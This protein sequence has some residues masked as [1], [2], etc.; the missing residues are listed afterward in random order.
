MKRLDLRSEDQRLNDTMEDE[1]QSNA[2]NLL[3]KI[4][5][6]HQKIKAE[7]MAT[8]DTTDQDDTPRSNENESYSMRRLVPSVTTT[9]ENAN[10]LTVPKGIRRNTN[11]RNRSAG[12]TIVNTA[13]KR[14]V[15][16]DDDGIAGRVN[17]GFESDKEV[18]KSEDNATDSQ[19]EPK[20]VPKPRRPRSKNTKAGQD[21]VNQTDTAPSQ[22]VTS[23]EDTLITAVIVHQS[24]RLR[25]DINIYH[26]IVKVHILDLDMDG[27]YVKKSNK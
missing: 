19:P 12:D 3:V 9:N 20:R 27:Q 22:P 10:T 14:T 1:E 21:A 8:Q 11:R 15:T 4:R 17:E 5:N 24:D 7:M 18:P 6:R 13:V 23:F 2:A 26:P 25:T 16:Y